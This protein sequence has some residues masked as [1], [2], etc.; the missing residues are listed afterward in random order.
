M[1]HIALLAMKIIRCKTNYFLNETKQNCFFEVDRFVRMENVVGKQKVNLQIA[2]VKYF[3]AVVDPVV[4]FSRLFENMR[5]T[6]ST[7]ISLSLVSP[8]SPS[9]F[10][11]KMNCSSSKKTVNFLSLSPGSSALHSGLQNLKSK[12]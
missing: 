12:H 9:C 7:S 10:D 11:K 3:C 1:T 6:S 8:F 4:C 2:F 5:Y